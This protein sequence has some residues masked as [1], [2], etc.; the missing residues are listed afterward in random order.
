MKKEAPPSPYQSDV[1]LIV[2]DVLRSPGQPLDQATRAFF[3]P[4]FGHDFSGVRVHTG[5]RAAESA[6]A[7]DAL[8]YT[9]GQD[10]VFGAGQYSTQS[11]EGLKILGHEL[12]HTIQQSH[13]N[14]SREG[15][16]EIANNSHSLSGILQRDTAP[17]D[18][19]GACRADWKK[20]VDIDHD[21]ALDMLSNTITKIASYNG[22]TPADVKSALEKYFK[23]SS[24]NFAAWINFNLR[25]LRL[26]APLAGYQC[27]LSTCDGCNVDNRYG[28]SMWC[29]PFTD[30]R[31]CDPVYFAMSDRRRSMGLVHEWVPST[32][33]ISTLAIAP[34]QG[35]QEALRDHYLTRIPGRNWC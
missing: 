26:M 9:V 19:C 34:A 27:Q 15:V 6:R 2:H 22:T 14:R 1:P 24:N 23:E 29:I 5:S 11:Y 17:P 16:M 21:R 18:A 31:V 8:A 4:R 35:A 7:I 25:Y 33:A 13:G 3:E 30:I 28:W 20:T 10:V 12:A 32:D